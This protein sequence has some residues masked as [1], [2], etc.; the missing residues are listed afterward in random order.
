MRAGRYEQDDEHGCD[1]KLLPDHDSP[2]LSAHLCST[3]GKISLDFASYS[4]EREESL[5]YQG[6][7]YPVDW[8]THYKT[9]A[10]ILAKIELIKDKLIKKQHWEQ[11]YYYNFMDSQA[12]VPVGTKAS[13]IIKNL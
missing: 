4:V 8:R 6:E 11:D 2:V 12:S 3:A 9:K 13:L 10:R 7:S 5:W 1:P